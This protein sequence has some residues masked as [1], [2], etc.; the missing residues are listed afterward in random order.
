[1]V[2]VAISFVSDHIETLHELDIELVELASRAGIEHCVRAPSLNDGRPFIEA[3]A[4]IAR[5]ALAQGGADG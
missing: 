3:L 5:R 1:V 4:G 2:L